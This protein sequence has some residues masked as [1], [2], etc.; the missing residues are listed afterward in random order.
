MAKILI[1]PVGTAFDMEYWALLLFARGN[2]HITSSEPG[3]L[4]A[5][6]TN[7]YMLD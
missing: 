4:A 2:I 3:V 5:I 6:N 1:S 7:Y